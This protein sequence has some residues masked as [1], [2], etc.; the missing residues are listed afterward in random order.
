MNGKSTWR[1]GLKKLLL[2]IRQQLR[3]SIMSWIQEE[4]DMEREK[5]IATAAT[6]MIEAGIADSDV[7]HLLQKYW[8]LRPSET[9]PFIKL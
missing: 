7:A 6:A 4:C 8:D 5:N 3:E 2:E 1:E 9:T